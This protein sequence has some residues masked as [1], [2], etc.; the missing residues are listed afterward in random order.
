MTTLCP[1]CHAVVG[2][3]APS[4]PGCGLAF[5]PARYSPTP[6]ASPAP[7]STPAFR[8]DRSGESDAMHGKVVAGRFLIDEQ[9]GVGGMGRVYKARHLGLDK[10]VCLKMLKPS[11]L[12]DA[13]IVSRFEREAKA[14]SRL[15]HPN[16]V[17]VLD[18]GQDERGRLYLVME[19]VAGQDLRKLLHAEGPLGARRLAAILSQVLSAL[20]RAHAM[21]VIH[22]DLKP[23]NVLVG[24]RDGERD[25]VKVLDFGIAKLQ[26]AQMPGLTQN[27]V[28]CGTPEYMS[29]EQAMGM[30]VDAR[31]DLYAVGVMLYQGLTGRLPLSGRTPLEVLQKQVSEVPLSVRAARPDADCSPAL[32][33]LVVRALAKRPEERPQSA[34]AFRRE[35]MEAA[36]LVSSTGVTQPPTMPPAAVTHSPSPEV[37][38]AAPPAPSAPSLAALE[39]WETP[40]PRRSSSGGMWIG[41]VIALGLVGGAAWVV[42][43]PTPEPVAAVE[44][45]DAGT[46]PT[47][48]TVADAIDLIERHNDDVRDCL[49]KSKGKPAPGDLV[50]SLSIGA[51][52][53]VVQANIPQSGL[54]APKVEACILAL[55]K[56][57]TFPPPTNP[58]LMLSHTYRFRR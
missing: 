44:P 43:R 52:G 34:E 47:G 30:D 41:I 31:A 42:T 20:A 36:G 18:F 58:P 55:A 57:W 54:K 11:L 16:S 12:D 9:I 5:A 25:F 13:T 28:V 37:K 7:A 1:G 38:S 53:K 46:E 4:C 29:P 48:L 8:T 45:V 35:L 15:D 19:Y 33:R 24:E 3:E 56:T 40:P 10:V 27:D 14:A 26:D 51:E 49:K 2:D 21:G 17:Q 22:R 39:G 50:L 23:E 6:I 32:E